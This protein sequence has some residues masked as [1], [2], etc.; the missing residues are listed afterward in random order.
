MGIDTRYWGPS[1]WQLFHYISFHA[2]NPRQF[3]IGIKDILPCR[4]CRESTTKFMSELP[5]ITD[6]AKWVYDL[7]NKVN[8]KLRTQCKENSEVIN[9]GEDPTFDEVKQKY[10]NMK[11]T[12]ILGRDFLFSISANYPKI[13][14][15]ADMAT[16][17]IFLKQLSEVYPK[18]FTRYLEQHPAQLETRNSY[19]KW[20]Y[21]LF[22]HLYPQADI[23]TFQGYAQRLAYY[24]SGCD[25]KT[26][27]GKTCRRIKGGGRTKSRD[28]RKT[29]KIAYS[30]LLAG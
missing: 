1:G 24:T 14:E 3:L 12:G 22:K 5:D 19:M 17:R 4:F 9:P 25:K 20:M 18:K 29:K 10:E 7:H 6:P 2:K 28:H 11:L 26:Y 27:K 21:G 15:E 16:Q 8:D 13:P 30:G 23:P